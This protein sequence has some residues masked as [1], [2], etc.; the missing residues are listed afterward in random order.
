[1]RLQVE[2][3]HAICKYFLSMVFH[4]LTK[5]VDLS[6]FPLHTYPGRI[7]VFHFVFISAIIVV[8]YYK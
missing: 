3:E 2:K 8:F 5:K 4:Y 6:S 7:G 1:M